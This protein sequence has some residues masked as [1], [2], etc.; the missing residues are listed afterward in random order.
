MAAVG[1]PCQDDFSAHAECCG[2]AF[3]KEG[4]NRTFAAKT[5]KVRNSE[6]FSMRARKQDFNSD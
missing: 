4:S 1:R 5:I 2:T 6:G 3:G